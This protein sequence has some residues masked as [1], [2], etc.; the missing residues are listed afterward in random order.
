M[1][2]DIGLIL[3]QAFSHISPD[4]TDTLTGIIV[5]QVTRLVV[6]AVDGRDIVGQRTADLVV[7]RFLR[8]C[9]LVAPGQRDFPSF[10]RHIGIVA[11]G[12]RGTEHVGKRFAD[13]VHIRCLTDVIVAIELQT[14]VQHAEVQSDVG[15]RSRFP[16]Q[17][18]GH[19]G[20]STRVFVLQAVQDTIRSTDAQQFE[21]AVGR[22]ITIP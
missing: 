12:R 3:E 5:V 19:D 9:E 6:I 17:S 15:R 2:V 8:Q 16:G 13:R 10:G 18:V 20:R 11:F 14:V 4:F 7:E 22:N 21:E 1:A